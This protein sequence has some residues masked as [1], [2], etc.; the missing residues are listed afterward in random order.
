MKVIL[1]ILVIFLL[2]VAISGCT[3]QPV[4]P[5]TGGE[6]GI[7]DTHDD[8]QTTDGEGETLA[9]DIDSEIADMDSLLDDLN[10][11]ELDNLEDDLAEIDW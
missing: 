7:Q 1:S 3:Q 9:N 10:D 5:N 11:S 4:T 2:V 8:G 6:Q